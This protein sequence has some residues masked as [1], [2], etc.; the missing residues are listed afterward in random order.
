MP[1]LPEVE[2]IKRD[3]ETKILK[4]PL[5][6]IKLYDI[7]YL[8]RQKIVFDDLFSLKGQ[9]LNNIERRGKYLFFYFKDKIL[10]IH[11]GLTGTLILREKIGD[12]PLSMNHLILSFDFTNYLIY[13]R[14]IRKFGKLSLI[15]KEK[16][17]KF[18]ASLGEDAL[19]ISYEGFKK[20]ISLYKRPL[21]SF[22][23]SQKFVSGLGNIYTD[24]LLFRAKLSPFKKGCEL[25][26]NE[27]KNLFKRMKELL[28]KAI[29]LRGSSIKNYVDGRGQPGRFQEK[30]LVY[31]KRGM[32]CLICGTPLSYTK[33]QQ[34]GTTY[35]P[36]C[37][38]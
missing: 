28:Q 27:I 1:E 12:C 29:E 36:N 5:K 24:E 25:T 32:P 9:I 30:H 38:K 14:D 23:L 7:S 21:K 3:L 35:C 4:V 6:D 22:F 17:E 26:E 16:G 31:G 19:N 37:Q 11:L 15:Q 33:F 10:L 13:L 2:T 34:R 20:K 8:K 18:L